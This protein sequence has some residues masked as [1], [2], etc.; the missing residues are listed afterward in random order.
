MPAYVQEAHVQKAYLQKQ[1]SMNDFGMYDNC[2]ECMIV[3]SWG[4]LLNMLVS[5]S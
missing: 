4:F 5:A 1:W 2:R 3:Y